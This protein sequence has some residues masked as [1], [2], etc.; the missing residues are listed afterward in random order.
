M[1]RPRVIEVHIAELVLHGFDPHDRR[2][3]SDAV[4]REL[5]RLF[6]KRGLTTALRRWAVLSE[7]AAPA[8]IAISVPARVGAHVA[9]AVDRRLPG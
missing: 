5:A 1:T 2:T 9:R 7:D 3:I 4:S 8:A 6:T